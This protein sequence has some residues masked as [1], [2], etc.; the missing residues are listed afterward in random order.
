LAANIREAVA[1]MDGFEELRA[2]L[3]TEETE[4]ASEIQAE[5]EVEQPAGE[6]QAD[7]ES[8]CATVESSDFC[9]NDTSVGDVGFRPDMPFEGANKIVFESYSMKHELCKDSPQKI[10][11]FAKPINVKSSVSSRQPIRS[12]KDKQTKEKTAVKERNT[13]TK[14]NSTMS[15]IKRRR[16]KKRKL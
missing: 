13:K 10:R 14:R 15:K 5:V 2:T 4:V 7:E 8:S 16:Y 12:K 1:E 6:T 11:A 3:A 9:S